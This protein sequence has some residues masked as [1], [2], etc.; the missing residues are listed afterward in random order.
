MGRYLD[1]AREVLSREAASEVM[2]ETPR[3]SGTGHCE[4]S[5][6]SELSHN[7]RPNRPD[8][9]TLGASTSGLAS[10]VARQQQGIRSADEVSNVAFVGDSGASSVADVQGLSGRKILDIH[11]T[12]T[13][14]QVPVCY[15]TNP[16]AAKLQLKEMA[17]SGKTLGADVETR[18]RPGHEEEPKAALSPTTGQLRLVQ[19]TDGEKVIVLDITHIPADV[20]GLLSK[21]KV[22]FHNA[23]FDLSFLLAAGVR[24]KEVSC[25]QLMIAA[26]THRPMVSLA[27]ACKT[28]LGVQVDKD[29]QT[30]D[31]TSP[32]LS[33]DQIE[34]AARD[35]V[36]TFALHEKLFE[37]LKVERLTSGFKLAR[38]CI[39]VIA[40]A[41]AHGVLLDTKAHRAL[42]LQ[43]QK[44]EEAAQDRLQTIFGCEINPKSQTQLSAWLCE[45]LD[46]DL[47]AA[48]PKSRTGQLRTDKDTLACFSHVALVQ[49]LFEYRRVS[50]QLATWGETCQR[51]LRADNRLHPDFFLLGARSGRMSC[52]N[53]NVH[54][55]PHDPA[56]RACFIAPPGYQLMA[57][58]FAQIELRIAGLLSGDN[59][60]RSVYEQGRDLHRS[61]VAKVK[62][63]AEKDVSDEERKLGK[64]INFGVLYGAGART[65]QTRA[66]VDHGVDLSLED[67]RRFKAAFEQTY[68]RLYRWQQAQ[69][70][71]AQK[72][73][74]LRTVSGRLVAVRDRTN[75]YTDA[76]N[77]V[78]QASGADLQMHAIQR[79]HS[80][81]RQK[82]LPAHLI[83]FVH[84]DLVLEVREDVVDVVRE[85][86]RH[87]MTEAFLDLFRSYQ[88]ESMTQGLVEV[89]WG[90]N[91]AEAK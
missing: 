57:A 31:W 32:E 41:K 44:D 76:R 8:Q 3:S 75:C 43:W 27:D 47:R 10:G 56:L 9:Q 13:S 38:R 17:G 24:L 46:Q 28:Y 86:L 2:D 63:K 42:V 25:T 88:P 78:I 85:L 39:P 65:F 11:C 4:K 64:A 35:A 74:T 54:A 19:V 84:D 62:D 18:P 37:K 66:R 60:I 15:L 26:L 30:S 50:H 40:D 29:L 82:D 36:L 61:I 7:F 72:R 81:L 16:N 80:A 48:W 51:H 69:H 12:V 89:G 71:E 1:I 87:E 79:V 59:M 53:P 83:N 90:M 33:A 20:L 55:L 58:D 34:Y 5:E 23:P 45:N 6:I 77:Y 68:H 67:A 70:R 14:T 73:G 91:Y 49:P 22:V 21:V 52:K